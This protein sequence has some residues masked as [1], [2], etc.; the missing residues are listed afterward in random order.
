MDF[1]VRKRFRGILCE[2]VGERKGLLFGAR[3]VLA[4]GVG[5]SWGGASGVAWD[6][7]EGVGGGMAGATARRRGGRPLFLEWRQLWET[8][9]V[10]GE[11]LVRE[12]NCTNPTNQPGNRA[13]DQSA[14]QQITQSTRPATFGQHCPLQ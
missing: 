9:R 11:E 4:A 14:K 13:A 8:G 5:G 6:G 2:R 7:A 3:G 12:Y 1:R 10:E